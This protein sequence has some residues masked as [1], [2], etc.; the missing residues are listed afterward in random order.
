MKAKNTLLSLLLILCLL[1]SALPL[2]AVTA[3]AEEAV[4]NVIFMIGDGMGY[5]QIEAGSVF[6]GAPLTFQTF[7]HQTKVDTSSASGVTDSAAAATAMATGTKTYNSYIGLDKNQDKVENLVEFS[8]AR[9]L[10]TGVVATQ[11]LPHATPAGFTAHTNSRYSYNTIAVQQ[12]LLQPDVL[13]GGGAT[14]FSNR[15]Q[16]IEDNN[17]Q[18]VTTLE[19][20][21]T[22][23]EDK[24]LLGVFDNNY[25]SADE[26]PELADMT[27]LTLSR[28]TGENG[29]FA[30]IEGSDID[31]Y[32]H[33]NDMENMLKELMD[34]DAAVAVAKDYADNNPGTLL[35]VTADH[36]TGGLNVPDGATKE[37]LTDSL[38]SSEAHTGSNVPLYAYGTKAEE[39]CSGDTIA[40]TDIHAFITAQLNATYGEAPETDFTNYNDYRIFFEKPEDWQGVKALYN[41][42]NTF[43]FAEYTMEQVEENIYSLTFYGRTDLDAGDGRLTFM[44]SADI[45]TYLGDADLSEKIN[46]RDATAIQK[47]VAQLSTLTE[48]GLMAADVNRDTNTNIKDATAIQKHVAQMETGYHIG[49]LKIREEFSTDF[50]GYYK[51]YRP[52]TQQWEDYVPTRGI[53]Y[54]EKP[55]TWDEAVYMYTSGTCYYGTFPGTAMSKVEGKDNLYQL[56]VSDDALNEDFLE[57]SIIFSDSVNKY[58]TTEVSFAG[59]NKVFRVFG[60]ETT[61]TAYG[62]WYDIDHTPEAPSQTTKKIYLA[63]ETEW[64]IKQSNADLFVQCDGAAPIPLTYEGKDSGFARVWSADIPDNTQAVVF[65]RRDSSAPYDLWNVFTPITPME[66]GKN[67]YALT[68]DA[69][70]YWDTE[71]EITPDEVMDITNTPVTLY[72]AVPQA[73]IDAGYTVKANRRFDNDAGVQEWAQINMTDTGNTYNGKKIY[74][75]DF[76]LPYG[77]V[78]V[79][80]FQ[81]YQGS[82]WKSQT[83]AINEEWTTADKINGKLFDGSKFVD[84]TPGTDVGQANLTKIHLDATAFSWYTGAA[85]TVYDEDMN[86]LTQN[87]PLVSMTIPAG[88]TPAGSSPTTLYSGYIPA[89]GKYIQFF[90][91]DGGNIYNYC[92][93]TTDVD[94]NIIEIEDDLFVLD[95][96]KASSGYRT[97]SWANMA[98]AT[99]P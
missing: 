50:E 98:S 82:T 1:I 96:V 36:E 37:D 59:F 66:D 51:L 10:R 87:E 68:D 12:I 69:G 35:I 64:N 54:F 2:C 55:A 67:L 29:F 53:I 92:C 70:G 48:L 3:G 79:L 99:N 49:I 44:D 91:I 17:F 13:M 7:E 32:C 83:V 15:Q 74:K 62:Y 11:V 95:G 57:F 77:G 16:L 14:Y 28:L 65:L 72:Y 86:I 88:Y 46:V 45:Y 94:S 38:F 97:G 42:T 93:T 84:Y 26:D 22:V 9:G 21:Y 33:Q 6:K 25:I 89:N 41:P 34:F 56:V 47:H 58:Q 80:Q 24:N 5:E 52:E 75:A 4:R 43:G 27:A 61:D 39:L 85:V 71:R 78:F 81:N 30:M 73:I 76:I 63:D 18:M 19:D 20:A 23:P 60:E 8:K 31:S 90:R 40:N